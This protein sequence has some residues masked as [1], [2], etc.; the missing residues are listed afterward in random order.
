VSIT[1]IADRIDQ[2]ADCLEAYARDH[3][4]TDKPVPSVFHLQAS[5]FRDLAKELRDVW[6][7]M[8]LEAKEER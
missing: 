1:D 3:G 7:D 2:Q 5:H 6:D 8:S 4:F